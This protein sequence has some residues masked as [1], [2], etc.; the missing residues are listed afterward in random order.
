M[1]WFSCMS[2]TELTSLK[3]FCSVFHLWLPV[4]SVFMHMWDLPYWMVYTASSTDVN[5][6]LIDLFLRIDGTCGSWTAQQIILERKLRKFLKVW[7]LLVT[8]CQR[9]MMCMTHLMHLFTCLLWPCHSYSV[10]M[11]L[12]F[13]DLLTSHITFIHLCIAHWIKSFLIQNKIEPMFGVYSNTLCWGVLM[14][15]HL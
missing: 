13:C 11:P 4:T 8:W 10:T 14:L 6:P 5:G 2:T 12:L 15:E 9:G 1:K 3:K 7:I